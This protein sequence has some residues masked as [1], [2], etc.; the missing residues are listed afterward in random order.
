MHY[1]Y[2][3][4]GMEDKSALTPERIKRLED[5]GFIWDVN[6]MI[7]MEKFELLREY[8]NQQGGGDEKLTLSPQL[9]RWCA[10]QRY[11]YKNRMQQN[12]GGREENTETGVSG[13][14]VVGGRKK[15]RK[16]GKICISPERIDLLNS[17]GFEWNPGDASWRKQCA[18]LKEYREQTGHCDVPVA[19][20]ENPELGHWVAN[21]KRICRE[22]T[23]AIVSAS[24]GKSLWQLPI[25]GLNDERMKALRDL[26][27]DALPNVQELEAM[28]R[29]AKASSSEKSPIKERAVQVTKTSSKKEIVPFPWD[30]I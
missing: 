30:E 6:G 3:E 7:W 11:Q 5:L 14:N 22:Y 25:T 9:S 27:F 1:G 17:I 2:I 15:S 21:Q 24:A 8:H 28:V 10:Q 26:G 13:S 12:E 20:P 16:G 18:A 19:Y 23:N 4:R 29:N